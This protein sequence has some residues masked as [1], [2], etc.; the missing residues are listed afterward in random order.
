[1]I[2]RRGWAEC[3]A[4]NVHLDG[5]ENLRGLCTLMAQSCLHCKAYSVQG[6]LQ[7][8]ARQV[9]T[10]MPGT[11]ISSHQLCIMQMSDLLIESFCKYHHEPS[12]CLAII[13]ICHAWQ[14]AEG[15]VHEASS[16]TCGHSNY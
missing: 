4:F 6:L 16:R 2:S 11:C 10:V 7:A 1:M 3:S 14:S 5:G 9:I 8:L 12:C 15:I 13:S